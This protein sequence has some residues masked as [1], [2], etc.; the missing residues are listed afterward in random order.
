VIK[1]LSFW[2]QREE[3]ISRKKDSYF[4]KGFRRRKSLI[5]LRIDVDYP[6]PSRIKSFVHTA[7]NVQVRKD[8]LK[9]SKILAR[10]INDSTK[11]VKAYWFFTPKTI[12][13]EELL[14]MLN[15]EKHEVA[16]HVINN[17]HAEMKLLEKVTK[18]Q[19]RYYTVHGTSRL[20]GRVLWKRWKTKAPVIPQDFPLQSFHQ[21]PTMG[22]DRRCYS[23]STT[24][25]AKIAEENIAKG[26]VLQI[27][28]EWLFQRG[29]IN[30]RGPYYAALRKILD[31]DEEFDN[32]AVQKK[33]FIKIGRDVGEYEKD[34]FPTEKF[35]EKLKDMGV[36]V[37]TFIERKWHHAISNPSRSWIKADDNVALLRVPSYDEWWQE[38][39]KKTRNMVRKAKKSGV[40]IKVVSLDEKLAE[41]IWKIYN[42]TPIRQGR[43]FPYYGITLQT[44]KK[45]LEIVSSKNGTFIGAYFE[46]ELVGF[47]QLVHGDDIAIISQILSR[48]EQWDKAVNNALLAK[49]IEVCA[50]QQERWLM[51]GRIGN[52]PSLDRF[53]QNHG[54]TKFPL[55]R[56]YVPLTTKGKIATKLGLHRDVKDA[57]PQRITDPLI[58]FYNWISRIRT[59]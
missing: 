25:V 57:L 11:Q 47:I 53:K 52:H 15:S 40:T 54:F 7:L 42:E 12:P 26:M 27:H 31:V 37:F 32:L 22:L 19:L 35:V 45:I 48:Q 43:A 3:L 21:F 23:N 29:I 34:V 36:D 1:F 41:G 28:P 2:N 55:T 13:D 39:G 50:N 10:M 18:K 58:P 51:Y 30:T 14:L 6:Y 8:Y 33:L 24:K 17:P 16:L 38:I 49:A 44:V 59:K 20:L 9:N 46:G 4:K 5:K 56:Y